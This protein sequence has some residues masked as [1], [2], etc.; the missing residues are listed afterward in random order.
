[1]APE[2]LAGREATPTSDIYALGLVLYELFTGAS[3]FTS[4]SYQDRVRQQTELGVVRPSR[5]VADLDL[6]VEEVILQC[7]ATDPADRP[8][9]ALAVAAAL[10][11]GDPLAATLA[12][13]ETP[14][15]EVVAAAGGVGGLRPRTAIA[16]VVAIAAGIA[17]VALVGDWRQPFF[18]ELDRPPEV[19]THE[20][21]RILEDLGPEVPPADHARGFT[22]EG[23]PGGPRR[24]V[25]WY[26]QSPRTLAEGRRLEYRALTFTN[27]ALAVPGMAGVRL[28]VHGVLVEYVRVPAPE[29][30]PATAA[31]DWAG[32]FQRAGLDPRNARESPP[33][34]VPPVFGDERHAWDV[35]VTGAALRVEAASFR[36]RPVWF[37]VMADYHVPERRKTGPGVYAP[38]SLWFLGLVVAYRNLRMGRGDREGAA[39]FAGLVALSTLLAPA[40][41]DPRRLE[42]PLVWFFLLSALFW[43]FTYWVLYLA[44]EPIVRR[45]WPDTLVSWTRLLRGRPLDPL[46]GHDALLG[47]LGGVA[48]TL[49]EQGLGLDAYAGW[50]TS[51]ALLAG[52][53]YV[54][55]SLVWAYLRAIQLCLAALMLLAL[56]RQVVRKPWVAFVVGVP[57][58]YILLGELSRPWGW[59]G[60]GIE[61]LSILTLGLSLGLLIR[62]GLLACVV[63]LTVNNFL[64]SALMTTHLGAWYADSAV[65]GILATLALAAWAFY[66]A[67]QA[68]PSSAAPDRA[69]A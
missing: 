54:F 62:P 69:S 5:R 10:P 9:S 33:T 4:T 6:S 56:L 43:T 63:A 44:L 7:L 60:W 28:D 48:L 38:L 13:G 67:L 23:E 47:V 59:R 25:F 3:A 32:L 17:L 34:G 11:G 49:F 39:R 40:L 22:L 50:P 19:L 8:S 45:R 64:G 42:P 24:L 26:R 1:M 46:V 30:S 12:A 15:P 66:A 37:E 21:R 58:L 14:S 55:G 57:V 41:S 36:G 52:G 16:G 68:R 2:Q 27:P 20:A 31:L 29:E 53:W 51:P 35:D 18:H 61:L 65:A